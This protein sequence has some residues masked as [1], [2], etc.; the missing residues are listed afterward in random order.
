MAI[1]FRKEGWP[2]D[3]REKDSHTSSQVEEKVLSQLIQRD[4]YLKERGVRFAS[5]TV[6]EDDGKIRVGVQQFPGPSNLAADRTR[7][8]I[9]V[10]RRV[11]ENWQFKNIDAE[12][13]S[14]YESN[15]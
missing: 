12:D 15:G 4:K 7:V 3:W 2:K 8:R 14:A 13:L 1:P 10:E 5:F 6:E 9:L 11:G